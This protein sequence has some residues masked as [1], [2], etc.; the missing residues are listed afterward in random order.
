MIDT[1]AG[2]L[3]GL[4]KT[5]ERENHY[6]YSAPIYEETLFLYVNSSARFPFESLDD[7][8]G[9]RIGVIR[10]WSYG[11]AFDAAR[12]AGVFQI[13]ESESDEINA[14]KLALGRLDAAIILGFAGDM[15]I[16]RFGLESKIK[17]LS[18]P[19]AVNETF[20]AFN[21]SA[22][23]EPLLERFNEELAKMKQDGVYAKIISQLSRL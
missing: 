9:K 13:E 12:G 7:L 6:D 1:G 22:K 19:I 11:N 18:K 16:A 14:Q 20:L 2:G 5:A 10:G 3:G 17:P 23:N 8:K 21:K 15:I 4:Y